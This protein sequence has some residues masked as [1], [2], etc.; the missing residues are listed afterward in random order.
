MHRTENEDDQIIFRLMDFFP[1]RH[2]NNNLNL[3][4][5][6]S[7]SIPI[8]ILKVDDCSIPYKVYPTNNNNNVSISL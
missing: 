7:D 5:R 4:M 2:C 3:F 1:S 6:N 8:N